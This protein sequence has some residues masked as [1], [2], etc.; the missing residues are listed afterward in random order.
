VP[1]PATSF[2]TW[3]RRRKAAWMADYVRQHDI[4]TVLFVG[5][6]SEPSS[7][8]ENMVEESVDRFVAW[9]VWSGLTQ[10]GIGRYV[11]CDGRHLPFADRSFDLV[12]SNAVIE[13]VGQ[14]D[15]QALLLREHARVGRHWVATTPNRWFPVESHTRVLLRHWSAAWRRRQTEF[16]R[17]LSRRELAA[18]LPPGSSLVGSVAA[19]TFI[20][21]GASMPAR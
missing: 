7:P 2:R 17:L 18:I 13:H 1:D 14:A 4:A 11:A 3:N 15:E 19:P 6:T 8:L 20:A 10:R 21:H 12:L 5:C 16:T 9:S